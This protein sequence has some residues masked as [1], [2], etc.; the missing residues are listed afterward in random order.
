MEAARIDI[1][2]RVQGVGY[3]YFTVD[4][5]RALGLSGWVRNRPD[6]TVE[7][8]AQGLRPQIEALV[9]RCHEGPPLAV[10]RRVNV[11]WGLPPVPDTGFEV[12]HT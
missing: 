7:I 6:G 2:G 8:L 11:E 3:R 9:A 1:A 12:R 10:V 5:A 4:T